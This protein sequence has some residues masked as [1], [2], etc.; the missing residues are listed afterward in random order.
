MQV[1]E[2]R[3]ASGAGEFTLD[4]TERLRATVRGGGGRFRAAAVEEPETESGRSG[5][6]QASRVPPPTA[7]VD[8][9]P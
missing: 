6:S 5:W 8:F 7:R 9:T 1:G 4:P 3:D 2:E